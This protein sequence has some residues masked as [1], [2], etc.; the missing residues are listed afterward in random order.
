MLTMPSDTK[1]EAANGSGKKHAFESALIVVEAKK[2]ITFN[3]GLAQCVSYLDTAS[4]LS[5]IFVN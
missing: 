2:A 1:Y 3:A 5:F 4:K